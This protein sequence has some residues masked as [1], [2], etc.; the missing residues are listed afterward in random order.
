MRRNVEDGTAEFASRSTR[1]ALCH[2]PDDSKANFEP[3]SFLNPGYKNL[4]NR[5]GSVVAVQAVC[6]STKYSQ[7]FAFIIIFC[8]I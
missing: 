6:R 5:T 8:V 4:F 3:Y 7:T 2:A 1:R